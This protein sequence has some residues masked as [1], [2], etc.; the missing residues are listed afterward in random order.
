MNPEIKELF[1]GYVAV[2]GDKPAAAL[3]VLTDVLS[4]PVPAVAAKHD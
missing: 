4:R 2:I 1:A 3:L